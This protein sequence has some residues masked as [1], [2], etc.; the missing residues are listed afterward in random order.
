MF[1]FVRNYKEYF[2]NGEWEGMRQVSSALAEVLDRIVLHLEDQSD[3]ADSFAVAFNSW[4]SY[5][6]SGT[7][8]RPSISIDN[9]DRRWHF[10]LK[11]SLFLM[12]VYT[13]ISGKILKT[14]CT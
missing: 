10:F 11:M 4:I 8:Q 6:L 14:F 3:L 7:L 2:Q 1:Q 12:Y 9:T 13:L 5:A